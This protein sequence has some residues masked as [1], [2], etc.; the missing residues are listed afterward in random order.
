MLSE[1]LSASKLVHCAD[2]KLLLIDKAQRRM[3]P[4]VPEDEESCLELVDG[5]IAF[6]SSRSDD[7]FII[8]D[9][10]NVY[11]CNSEESLKVPSKAWS[12]QVLSAFD[13]SDLLSFVT[14]DQRICLFDFSN[15]KCSAAEIGAKT[16][17]TAMAFITESNCCSQGVVRRLLVGD[18]CGYLSIY[19]IV[20]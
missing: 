11:F 7:F 8:N 6:A 18:D 20:R 16:C 2:G 10:G 17:I 1:S 19:R 13:G 5:R 4:F 9:A 14:S 15:G 12:R 3:I